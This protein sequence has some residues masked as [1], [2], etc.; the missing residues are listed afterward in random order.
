MFVERS[1]E[2]WRQWI[3]LTKKKESISSTNL[4][5]SAIDLLLTRIV[6]LEAES[7]ELHTKITLYEVDRQRL[8]K[9]NQELRNHN[10][11]Y[12]RDLK[13]RNEELYKF[14]RKEGREGWYFAPYQLRELRKKF[15]DE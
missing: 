13:N 7:V 8:E 3:K 15:P 6:E 10:A 2:E 12:I 11:H 9:E 14:A 1:N 4:K 5:A